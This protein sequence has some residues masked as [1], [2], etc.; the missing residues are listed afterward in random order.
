MF[1]VLNIQSTQAM[2][3]A[4]KELPAINEHQLLLWQIRGRSRA[5]IALQS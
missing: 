2:G 5:G 1:V 4:I 3:F